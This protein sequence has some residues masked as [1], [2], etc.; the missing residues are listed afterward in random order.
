MID[1]IGNKPVD[2]VPWEISILTYNR[3]NYKGRPVIQSYSVY[4]GAL[5]Q[6]NAE[7]YASAL[8]PQYVLYQSDEIDGRYGMYDD[9]KLKLEMLRRYKL[10]DPHWNHILLKRME[11]ARQS[12]IVKSETGSAKFDERIELTKTDELQVGYL[13]VEYS[14]IGSIFRTLYQPPD[15][16]VKLFLDDGTEVSYRCVQ[17]NVRDGIIINRFV[18]NKDAAELALFVNSH[19]ALSKNVKAIQFYSSHPAGFKDTFSYRIEHHKLEAR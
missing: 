17:P 16:N 9:T 11:T 3:L 5:D 4:D 12:S 6:L 15:L 1:S 8:A 13:N 18:P 14:F 2:I 10:I 7:F 19:G